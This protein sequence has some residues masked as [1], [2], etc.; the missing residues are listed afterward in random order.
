MDTIKTET[1]K[2]YTIRIQ[3][4]DDPQN[5]RDDDNLGTMVLLHRRHSLGDKHNYREADY[6]GWAELRNQLV[7]DGAVVVLP[8]YGY[9]HGGLSI[10]T[11]I[12]QGWWH[13]AWDG[14]RL[15]FIVAFRQDIKKVQGWTKITNARKMEII[16]QLMGEVEAYNTFLSGGYVGYTIEDSDEE[17]VGGCWGFDDIDY[18]IEQAKSEIDYLP[19]AK[20]E[21]EPS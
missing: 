8:V 13:Y 18:A 20:E 2:G 9:D 21:L 17:T 11:K 16:R 4:D 10:S 12:E 6:S 7:K 14:G 1:Y 5:P 15:G 19:A 3:P